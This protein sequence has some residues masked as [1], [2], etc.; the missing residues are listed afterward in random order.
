MPQLIV[1]MYCILP[2]DGEGGE[3]KSEAHAYVDCKSYVVL[4]IALEKPLIPKRPTSV[5]AER[6]V[7]VLCMPI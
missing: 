7:C 5:L 1:N 6:C 2:S 4:E 3:V